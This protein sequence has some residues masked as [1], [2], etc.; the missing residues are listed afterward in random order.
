MHTHARAW[1]CAHTCHLQPVAPLQPCLCREILTALVTCADPPVQ[2][3]KL[4]P[5]GEGTWLKWS[6]ELNLGP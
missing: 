6:W 5:G 3:G 1:T 4:S 2:P